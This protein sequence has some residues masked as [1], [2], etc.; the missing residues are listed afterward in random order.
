MLAL[1]SSTI[2]I[3]TA[4]MI[5]M[6]VNQKAV[7]LD[8]VSYLPM[9]FGQARMLHNPKRYQLTIGRAYFERAFAGCFAKICE[10][11]KEDYE[12][13]GDTE[14]DCLH[15]LG[16]P[17]LSECW[18]TS[19]ECVAVVIRDFMYVDIF[20]AISSGRTDERASNP[21]PTYVICTLEAVRISELEVVLTGQANKLAN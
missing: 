6:N 11:L 17:A 16:Y 4:L 5:S 7:D 1:G 13:C 20:D 12:I 21:T 3:H 19:H 15:Q 18:Q 14:P 2:H 8:A 9:N 10:E